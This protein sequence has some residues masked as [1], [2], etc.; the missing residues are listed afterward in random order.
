[1]KCETKVRIEKERYVKSE[2]EFE[3]LERMFG[4][5]YS[6]YSTQATFT[7]QAAALVPVAQS[8]SKIRVL[9]RECRKLPPIKYRT[10]TIFSVKRDAKSKQ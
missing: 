6:L 9:Y 5:L 3:I 8:S 10:S 7:L 1:M 2:T 4:F